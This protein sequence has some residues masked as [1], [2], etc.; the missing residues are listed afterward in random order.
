MRKWKAPFS[1]KGNIN[2][3]VS[4]PYGVTLET[5]VEYDY[6]NQCYINIP[7]E[8]EE[9]FPKAPPPPRLSGKWREI[10]HTIFDR[11]K[12][13]P[14]QSGNYHSQK[15]ASNFNVSGLNDINNR[16]DIENFDE[17]FNDVIYV[18]KNNDPRLFTHHL[19]LIGTGL[20][21]KVYSGIY[22]SRE[23]AIKEMKVRKSHIRY[24]AEEIH[25]MAQVHSKYLI[26]LIS[27]HL[28]DNKIWIL[29]E[30]MNGGTLS[31]IL[32]YIE[33]TEPQ[34]A[35][36]VNKLLKAVLS[37][38]RN[39]LIHRDIKCG[40]VFLSKD[41]SIKLGDFG[42][43]TQIS[44]RYNPHS[45]IVGSPYW[46]A[47]ELVSGFEYSFP[48]DIW[49]IG[50][51]CRELADGQPPLSE[52]P[53]RKAM[54]VVQKNGLNRMPNDDGK[55]SIEFIDFVDSCTRFN[56]EERPTIEELINHPFLSR[57][58]RKREIAAVVKEAHKMADEDFLDCL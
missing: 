17:S 13:L 47:P 42:F 5:K 31:Q 24:I 27:A 25:T 38:H 6:E 46:M 53:P 54:S 58:C 44:E 16:N 57:K 10:M 40:N 37:L 9:F 15:N 41:G 11:F 49:S 7:K 39:N 36:I 20:T 33:L 4:A 22:N 26:N 56:P 55:W 19:K 28:V 45:S 23:I 1:K 50:I 21:A 14:A 18:L 51:L 8:Y 43:A 52:L 34:I 35:Y 32:N 2:I 30:Y 12:K 3:S 29:M 48:I